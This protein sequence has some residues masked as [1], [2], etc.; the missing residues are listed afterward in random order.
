VIPVAPVV[1]SSCFSSSRGQSPELSVFHCWSGDPVDSGVLPDGS[2]GWVHQ[3]DLKKFEG[4]VLIDPVGIQ[5][6]KIGCTPSNSF[7][8]NG[9]QVSFG[10]ELVNTLAFWLSVHNSFT[11]GSLSS[12]SSHS[13]PE[14]HISLLGFVAQSTCLIWTR[15]A[16]G[17]MN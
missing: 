3:N 10:F 5:N 2:V 15:R 9:F 8:S 4:G 17:S 1:E 12:S 14:N 11:D 16:S 13:H 7:F 6:S